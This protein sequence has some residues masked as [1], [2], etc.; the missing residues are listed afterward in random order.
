MLPMMSWDVDAVADDANGEETVNP[1]PWVKHVYVR[2]G[3]YA[4][5]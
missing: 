5:A 4:R 2:G 3:R 1:V